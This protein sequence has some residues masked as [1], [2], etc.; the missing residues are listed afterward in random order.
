MYMYV[1]QLSEIN[2]ISAKPF[3]IAVQEIYYR[4]HRTPEQVFCMSTVILFPSFARYS[5]GKNN[6]NVA[7]THCIINNNCF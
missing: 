5:N 2:Y 6:N 1:F 7:L 4:P 3:D